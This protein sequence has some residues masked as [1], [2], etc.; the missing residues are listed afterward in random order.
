MSVRDTWCLSYLISMWMASSL[1]AKLSKDP[2]R[3][4]DFF[5]LIIS[6]V[7]KLR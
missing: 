7:V 1:K 2:E 5:F 4:E 6:L 3:G